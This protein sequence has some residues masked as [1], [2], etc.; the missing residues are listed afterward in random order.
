[1]I[2]NIGQSIESKEFFIFKINKNNF[3]MK[4]T[5]GIVNC[6]LDVKFNLYGGKLK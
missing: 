1:M 3:T 5:R 2:N 6:N 4:I